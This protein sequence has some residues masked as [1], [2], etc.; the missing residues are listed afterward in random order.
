MAGTAAIFGLSGG[1]EAAEAFAAGAVEAGTIYR[2][3]GDATER[4]SPNRRKFVLATMAEIE[5]KPK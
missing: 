5:H 4:I 2:V 3:P 1:P